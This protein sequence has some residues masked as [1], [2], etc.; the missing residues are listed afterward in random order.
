MVTKKFQAPEKTKFKTKKT[1]EKDNF[2][3][4]TYCN[5]YNVNICF[6]SNSQKQSTDKNVTKSYWSRALNQYTIQSVKF[7]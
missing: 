7:T 6:T 3:P 4:N 1:F 5:I 2:Q